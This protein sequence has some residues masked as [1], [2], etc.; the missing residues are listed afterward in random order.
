V[1]LV[2]KENVARFQIGQDGGQVAGLCDDGPG[3]RPEADPHFP[4]HDLGQRRLAKT[5][6]AGQQ[7]MVQRL[8]APAGRFNEDLEIGDGRLLADEIGKAERAQRTV[9]PIAG[10]RALVDKA[11]CAG[12][13]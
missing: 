7:D 8:L 9:P 13:F 11:I 3:S 12:G 1:N 2:D 10:L 6:R 4:R 5:G